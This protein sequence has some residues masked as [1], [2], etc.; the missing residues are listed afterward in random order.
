LEEGNARVYDVQPTTTPGE[1]PEVVG[2]FYS[3]VAGEKQVDERGE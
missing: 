1:K 3:G 2:C